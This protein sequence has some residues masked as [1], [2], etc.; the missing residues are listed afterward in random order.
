MS[1]PFDEADRPTLVL[2]NDE[3]Q[4]SLWPAHLAVPAG[5]RIA[6]GAAARQE[7]VDHI[8]RHWT[9]MRPRSVTGPAASPVTSPSPPHPS[10]K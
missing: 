9:D 1:N 5:W 7:C 6:F 10:A 2:V 8:D 4:Y 3:S